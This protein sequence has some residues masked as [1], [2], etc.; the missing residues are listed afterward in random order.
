MFLTRSVW[1]PRT[2]KRRAA[3]KFNRAGLTEGREHQGTDSF[4]VWLS[5]TWGGHHVSGDQSNESTSDPSA[6]GGGCS[7]KY[8]ISAIESAGS[9]PSFMTVSMTNPLRGLQ[10][11]DLPQAHPDAPSQLLV[12]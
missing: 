9:S 10:G 4:A 6:G 7:M 12:W 8:P 5:A 11:R 2:R 1:S 3:R